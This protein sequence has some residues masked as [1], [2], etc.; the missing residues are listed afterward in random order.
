[1]MQ[2]RLTNLQG[3]YRQR[4]GKNLTIRQMAE[5]TGFSKTTIADLSAGNTSR[6]DEKTMNVM[7][8]YLSK[9]LER[10]LTTDDLWHFEPDGEIQ[11]PAT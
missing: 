6:P 4:F 7:L 9:K 5:D 11:R 1:M 3:E 2:W 8:N 10:P